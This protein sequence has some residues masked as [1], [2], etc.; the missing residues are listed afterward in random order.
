MNDL[1]V[2]ELLEAL[3]ESGSEG[4]NTFVADS[5]GRILMLASGQEPKHINLEQ[6]TFWC[7]GEPSKTGLGPD[8]PIFFG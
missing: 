6:L 5:T 2:S 4:K 7:R 8:D 1:T 3:V